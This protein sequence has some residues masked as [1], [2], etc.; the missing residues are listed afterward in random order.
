MAAKLIKLIQRYY[1]LME[2]SAVPCC[3]RP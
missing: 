3:S 2:E 1:G